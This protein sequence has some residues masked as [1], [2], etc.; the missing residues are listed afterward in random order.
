MLLSGNVVI[1][2]VSNTARL[3][4][5]GDPGSRVQQVDE[6][7]VVVDA[8]GY[9]RLADDKFVITAERGRVE[10]NGETI[11]LTTDNARISPVQPTN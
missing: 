10:K 8:L 2:L 4:V 11:I 9:V 6:G 3:A 7:H 5:T 1:T